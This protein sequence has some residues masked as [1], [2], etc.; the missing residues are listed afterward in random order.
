LITNETLKA[1]VIVLAVVQFVALLWVLL[2]AAIA[3]IFAGPQIPREIELARMGAI[4]RLI[5]FKATLWSLFE[6]VALIASAIA[7]RGGLS[8]KTVAWIGFAGNFA[9]SVLAALIAQ[10][11]EFKCCGHL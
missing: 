4:D 10:T 1:L 5:E 11:F 8:A 9:L 6:L 2:F 7:F 3:L